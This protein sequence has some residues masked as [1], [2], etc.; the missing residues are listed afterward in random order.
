MRKSEGIHLKG[1]ENPGVIVLRRF[2]DRLNLFNQ[3]IKAEY[4]NS[5]DEEGLDN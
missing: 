5:Y 3:T 4:Q 2:S 1:F